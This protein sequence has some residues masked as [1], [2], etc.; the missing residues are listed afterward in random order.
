LPAIAALGGMLVPAAIY[1]ALNRYGEAAQ[2]WAIPMAT[3]IIFAVGA[4][5]LI[6]KADPIEPAGLHA[7][8]GHR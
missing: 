7:G 2:G 3:D 4:L 5:A 1:F 8:R 6:G